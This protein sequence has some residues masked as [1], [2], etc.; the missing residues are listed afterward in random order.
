MVP[1]RSLT[2]LFRN[3]YLS[4]KYPCI[5]D[6]RRFETPVRNNSPTRRNERVKRTRGKEEERKQKGRSER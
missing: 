4:Y 3:K 6:Y 2:L 1:S 5:P